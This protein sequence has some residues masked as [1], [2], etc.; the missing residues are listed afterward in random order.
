[1]RK[2]KQSKVTKLAKRIIYLQ[3]LAIGA[4]HKAAAQ[5]GKTVKD[6]DLICDEDGIRLVAKLRIPS[7]MISPEW[8]CIYGSCSE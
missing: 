3:S 7:K 8:K 2:T 1:M 6:A 5:F 4:T